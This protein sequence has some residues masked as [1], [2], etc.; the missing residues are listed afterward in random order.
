[1]GCNVVGGGGGQ[2]ESRGGREE[3]GDET[4]T[5]PARGLNPQASKQTP[6]RLQSPLTQS[7]LL[8]AGIGNAIFWF[9]IGPVFLGLH[10][11]PLEFPLS[12]LLRG[13]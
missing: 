12:L 1:M 9:A 10:F 5:L 8:R 11:F 4:L 13:D 6:G 2:W 3:I 7:R